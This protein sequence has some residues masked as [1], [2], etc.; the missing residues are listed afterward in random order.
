MNTELGKKLICD[1][2]KVK[3]FAYV[4]KLKHLYLCNAGCNTYKCCIKG[5][6]IL[7]LCYTIKF[8]IKIYYF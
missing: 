1:M 3:Y 2:K 6:Y 7:I 5:N 4:A 8:I